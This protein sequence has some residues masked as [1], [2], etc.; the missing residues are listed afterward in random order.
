[1]KSRINLLQFKIDSSVPLGFIYTQ[2]P[3]QSMPE[4][5]WPNTEWS[6]I[7]SDYSGLFF[8]AEGGQSEPFGQIQQANQSRISEVW[9]TGQHYDS[10]KG[11]HVH[12][13]VTH[14]AKNTHLDI[15]KDEGDQ[16]IDYFG[17]VTTNG[18]VRPE[19]T[20]IKIWKRIK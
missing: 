2:F 19:N 16:T 5:L 18:E 3:N 17:I 8:R 1:M 12:E 20:A 7:T 10:W 4:E 9:L 11:P 13:T 14:L 6:E 15:A